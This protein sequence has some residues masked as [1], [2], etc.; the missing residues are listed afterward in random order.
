MNKQIT[1]DQ[2]RQCILCIT[3][4]FRSVKVIRKLFGA[5]YAA[6]RFLL[7]LAS[8]LGSFGAHVCAKHVSF[9]SYYKLNHLQ[10]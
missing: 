3:I 6:R 10:A 2:I 8:H 9:S 4:D 5:G 7:A 1:V